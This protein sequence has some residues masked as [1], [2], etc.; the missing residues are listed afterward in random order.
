MSFGQQKD[1]MYR[2]FLVLVKTAE[3]TLC[4]NRHYLQIQPW[5]IVGHFQPVPNTYIW[6]AL[7]FKW[8][9]ILNV[10]ISL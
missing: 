1:S 9:S 7:A 2:Y 8:P 3:K 5:C 4:S 6:T 10:G